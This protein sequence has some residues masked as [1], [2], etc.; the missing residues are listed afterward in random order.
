K[1]VY[2]KAVFFIIV[3]EF[4]ERFSFYG[5][6]T[7]LPLYLNEVLG[8]SEDTST[9][10]YHLFAMAAYFTPLLGA[11]IA[12]SWLGKFQTILY[13]S[14]VYAAGQL[15]L[16][17]ASVPYF[18]FP[19]IAASF[20]GLLLIAIGT[21]GIKPC[22]SAF[23]GDQF[24][25]PEQ[26]AELSAFFSLFYMAINVGSLISTTITPL[27][28]QDAHCFDQASCYPLAFF[29]PALLMV[30]SVVVFF[31]G[32][33]MYKMKTPEGNVVFTV[34]KCV[35][36]ALRRKISSKEEHE[37]W[38]DYAEDKYDRALIEDIKAVM[39]VLWLFIPLP[40]FWALFDQQGSR[41]TFQA[42][43]MD[44]QVFDYFLKPDQFQ[45]INPLL[46]IIFIPIFQW[47]VYP[48][49]ETVFFINTP[50]RKMTVGG[51]L[52]GLAFAISGLVELKVE[53]TYA[54]QPFAGVG[55]LRIFNTINC[56]SS[57][58]VDGVHGSLEGFGM[59]QN[60][61]V[62]ITDET[63][64]MMVIAKYPD[65]CTLVEQHTLTGTVRVKQAKANTWVA[66]KEGILEYSKES[67]KPIDK[68]NSGDP[69]VRL[70]L[71]GESRFTQ[72]LTLHL[73]SSEEDKLMQVSFKGSNLNVTD[74]VEVKRGRYKVCA[75]ADCLQP[76]SDEMFFG[77][78]GIYTIVGSTSENGMRMKS[79]TVADP[80]SVHM[81][82]QLP[83][84][85]IITAG[86]I[87]FSITG[88]EFAFTQAPTSMKSLLSASW[89]LTVAIG[90][91]LVVLI[92]EG[93]FFNRQFLEILLF[94]IVMIVDMGIF[95]VMAMFYKYADPSSSTTDN[96]VSDDMNLD[97]K[98]SGVH[99]Q[100]Y[101][102][103][104]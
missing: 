16:S 67:D 63:R 66:T 23:G 42:K 25:L 93:H 96:S 29:V 84:Y 48:V 3:N 91:G 99:N 102:N 31:A 104:S 61:S 8:F 80:N 19:V 2:P 7:A 27:L 82:W 100:T 98:R 94:T 6:R 20:V 87:M 40:V 15:L 4:C 85:V 24:K 88:L 75:N 28:R 78:G 38:L 55:H 68:S 65:N 54:K 90:N 83:Q 11:I 39:K 14:I 43:R 5:M 64:D 86:E 52:A 44:G 46:I 13:L 45:M 69:L 18:H 21:G 97:G 56:S 101:T 34:S 70:L 71:Y 22:V 26:E 103:D 10:L 73:K 36:H 58:S 50:L 49:I 60:L 32:K 17:A 79:V 74:F 62:P 92:V 41:W 53:D 30:V 76:L 37:H 1:M 81:F 89:L 12:D 47:I 95:A 33:N 9:V 77:Y 57:L 59:Y 35:G 51:L 72:N